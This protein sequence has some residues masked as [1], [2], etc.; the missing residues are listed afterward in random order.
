MRGTIISLSVPTL[1]VHSLCK[2]SISALAVHFLFLCVGWVGADVSGCRGVQ[3]FTLRVSNGA[4]IR[5]SDE[6]GQFLPDMI[7][8]NDN[9]QFVQRARAQ[10][11][12]VPAG[13]LG[14]TAYL[15][16]AKYCKRSH[17]RV[18]LGESASIWKRIETGRWQQKD[19][20]ILFS[21]G[22][23]LVLRGGGRPMCKDERPVRAVPGFNIRTGNWTQHDD[24]TGKLYEEEEE[25]EEVTGNALAKHKQVVTVDQLLEYSEQEMEQGRPD[26]AAD[27]IL[28]AIEEVRMHFSFFLNE[29][30]RLEAEC[31][32]EGRGRMGRRG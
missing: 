22:L 3:S 30:L 10:H 18:V 7:K 9:D 25:E 1:H 23:C 5:S 16:N 12:H 4:E 17:G 19:D 6:C 27:L 29:I 20:G 28:V 8:M 26:C 2:V 24:E 31:E 21:E 11:V 14:Y 13:R 15:W 32:V